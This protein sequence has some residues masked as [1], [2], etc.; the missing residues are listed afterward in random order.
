MTTGPRKWFQRA[1]SLLLIAASCAQPLMTAAAPQIPA[2]GARI[3][4]WRGY[5]PLFNYSDTPISTI[6]VNGIDR[7]DRQILPGRWPQ[8]DC[9]SSRLNAPGQTKCSRGQ[10]EGPRG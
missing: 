5:E 9:S 4:F 6:P 3:W 7:A 10:T 1:S 8:I 2:G